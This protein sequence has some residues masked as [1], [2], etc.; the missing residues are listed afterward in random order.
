MSWTAELKRLKQD[1][2]R[3]SH[4][5]NRGVERHLVGSG[6][7]IEAA[8]LADELKRGVVQLLVGWSMLRVSQLF[9]VPAHG[10]SP[11][12]FGAG[13]CSVELSR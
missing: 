3:Q 6:W 9:D 1:A 5:L 8:D 2:G 12:V 10:V 7:G 13:S 11:S 4:V